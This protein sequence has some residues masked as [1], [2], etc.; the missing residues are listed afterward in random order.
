MY[1]LI[2]NLKNNFFLIFFK[3]FKVKRRLRK[4]I[5]LKLP[6]YMCKKIFTKISFFGIGNDFGNQALQTFQK[7][8]KG[9]LILVPV[10]LITE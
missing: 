6:I 2:S 8:T 5:N 9:F 10:I 1:H 4:F 3:K 7:I